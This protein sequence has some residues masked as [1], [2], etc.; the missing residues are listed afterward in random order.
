[1]SL[2]SFLQRECP[3]VYDAAANAGAG[4]YP[5]RLFEVAH[6]NELMATLESV[7]PAAVAA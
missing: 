7:R 3:D 1:M 4:A 6:V 5:D 2:L